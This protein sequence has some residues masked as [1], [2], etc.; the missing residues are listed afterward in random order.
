[1]SKYPVRE[2]TSGEINRYT[3]DT[4]NGYLANVARSDFY[5]KYENLLPEKMYK[6]EYLN[7]HHIHVDP[8]SPL[9]EGV[10]YNVRANT[11]YAVEENMRV[12]LFSELSRGASKAPTKRS[13]TL[14]GE[15]MYQSHYAYTECGLGAK[16]TDYLVNL[17]KKEGIANGIY[18]AKITG[19]GAG[20]TVAILADKKA[21]ATVKKIFD[22]Y[23]AAK[24]GEP[25]LFEGSSDGADTFGIK[26]VNARPADTGRTG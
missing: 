23:A 10:V 4:W 1:M 2:D 26:V 12:Q 17:C 11:R 25:Y 20:G 15:L 24:L 6:Q 3:D 13:F 8:F 19:G 14:M 5:E 18:G 21:G 7:K 16:A 22:T 9:K